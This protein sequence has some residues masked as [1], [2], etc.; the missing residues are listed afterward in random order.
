MERLELSENEGGMQ[1]QL[2][3]VTLGVKDLARARKFYESLGWQA[4]SKSKDNVVFFQLP[5]MSL[6]LYG[7]S[8][9]AREAGLV[10][11]PNPSRDLNFRGVALS[12]NVEKKEDVEQ[13][14]QQAQKAGGQIRK[15]AQPAPWGGHYGFFTDPD[16]HLWEVVWNPKVIKN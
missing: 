15:V 16:H 14:L 6:A 12:H 13:V 2:S 5:G 11:D 9:L 1:Q 8:D 10:E 4:S 3:V 7:Q